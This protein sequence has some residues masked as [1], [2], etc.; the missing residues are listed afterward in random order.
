MIFM[1]KVFEFSVNEQLKHSFRV[2]IE[3]VGGYYFHFYP[4]VFNIRR[5][6]VVSVDVSE[7]YSVDTVLMQNVHYG[8]AHKVPENRRKV[9]ENVFHTAMLF[10]YLLSHF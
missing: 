7:E 6:G 1:G 3:V 4:L 2:K 9:Q 8:S 5:R 10:A